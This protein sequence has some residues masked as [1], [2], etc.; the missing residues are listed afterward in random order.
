MTPADDK[1]AMTIPRENSRAKN[2][3]PKWE[4]TQ[5]LPVPK[6]TVYWVAIKATSCSKAV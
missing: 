6:Q 4:G 5:A 1:L 3:R 2:H